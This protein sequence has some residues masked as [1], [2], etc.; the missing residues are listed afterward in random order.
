MEYFNIS[1]ISGIIIIFVN[2]RGFFAEIDNER[3]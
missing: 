1:V 3:L 2:K